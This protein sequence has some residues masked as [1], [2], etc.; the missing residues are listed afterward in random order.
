LQIFEAELLL[1]CGEG[2]HSVILVE[3]SGFIRIGVLHRSGLHLDKIGQL[4]HA[5]SH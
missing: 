1:F 5:Q 4:A 3:M 2:A